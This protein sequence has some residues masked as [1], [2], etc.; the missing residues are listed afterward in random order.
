MKNIQLRKCQGSTDWLEKIM[1]LLKPQPYK[2]NH[3][4]TKRC[5]ASFTIRFVAHPILAAQFKTVSALQESQ[6]F[7]RS[8]L[9]SLTQLNLLDCL[10]GTSVHK[11][12][13]PNP[14]RKPSE[15]LLFTALVESR[16][17]SMLQFHSTPMEDQCD[18]SPNA[19]G[20]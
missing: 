2:T 9:V 18:I 11:I 14:M 5:D 7:R 6:D 17:L 19:A 16:F 8:H 20:M 10:A 12:F 15:I 4:L 3:N 1:Q 13:H